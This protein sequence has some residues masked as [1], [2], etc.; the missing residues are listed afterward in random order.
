M[1]KYFNLMRNR[2]KNLPEKITAFFAGDRFSNAVGCRIDEVGDDYAV[3]SLPLQDS[4]Y[5]AQHSVMGGAIFTLADFSFAVCAHVE[6]APAV[7]VSASV[8]FIHPPKGERI[9]ATARMIH[10][11]R[12]T[13][14]ATVALTDST[15][16][17]VATVSI[18]GMYIS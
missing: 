14:A 2:V 5:N 13:C 9:I 7:T 1:H 3:C 15:G 4:L 18:S 11:G 12:T 17:T 8:I 6:K 16:E 10:S